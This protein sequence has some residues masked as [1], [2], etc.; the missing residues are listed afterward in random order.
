MNITLVRADARA[1]LS[2][3]IPEESASCPV[4][5]QAKGSPELMQRGVVLGM[6]KGEHNLL[7]FWSLTGCWASQLHVFDITVTS[8]LNPS[9]FTEV[10]VMAGSA[11][12]AAEQ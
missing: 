1:I 7:M 6:T 3:I 10:S 11:A 8:P 5:T 9:T 2:R 4:A 12:L